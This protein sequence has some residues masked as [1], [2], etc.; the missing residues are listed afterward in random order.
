MV[1]YE[2]ESFGM[3]WNDMKWYGMGWN[4]TGIEGHEMDWNGMVQNWME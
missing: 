3:G 4:A 2:L 1:W